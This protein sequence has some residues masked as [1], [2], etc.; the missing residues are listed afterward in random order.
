MALS[1]RSVLGLRRRRPRSD[2]VRE[3][4]GPWVIVGGVALLVVIAAAWWY[5]KNS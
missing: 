2:A 3:G 4:Y 5:S 1:H